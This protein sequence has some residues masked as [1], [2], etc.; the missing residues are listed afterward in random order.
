M[1]RFNPV[2]NMDV[3]RSGVCVSFASWIRFAFDGSPN[4]NPAMVVTVSPSFVV[5]VRPGVG[6]FM[7]SPICSAGLGWPDFS[8][9]QVPGP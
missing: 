4:A 2:G 3:V 6:L 9:F 1:I 5:Y 8:L 7:Q